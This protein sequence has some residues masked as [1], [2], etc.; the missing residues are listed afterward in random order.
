MLVLLRCV[1]SPRHS[2]GAGAEACTLQRQ[3]SGGAAA[4][5]ADMMVR[6]GGRDERVAASPQSNGSKNFTNK[7]QVPRIDLG[8]LTG[9]TGLPP[10]CTPAGI[11]API[12]VETGSSYA[13]SDEG[14]SI[15]E[16]EV[17]THS[18]RAR[19]PTSNALHVKLAATATTIQ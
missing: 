2:L 9:G 3:M 15:D 17:S 1:S 16:E 6:G 13:E 18:G 14:G 19:L 11:A 7:M 10:A 4:P 8:A 12:H 5:D